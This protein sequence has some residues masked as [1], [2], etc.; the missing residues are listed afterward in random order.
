MKRGKKLCCATLILGM[1][2]PQVMGSGAVSEAASGKWRHNAKG[3]WY[4]YSDGSYAKNTWE[5][6]GG[7][8]YYFNASGYMVTGW[9]QIKGKW[10]YF[11]ASGCMVTGWKQIDGK[12]YLFSGSGVMV[13]G[14]KQT[15]NKNQSTKNWYFF[16][17]NGVMVTGWKKIS[18]KWYFFNASGVMVTGTRTIGGKEY[19]FGR[20]GALIESELA[21]AKVGDVILFGLY[22]Q[23]D[24]LS[25]GREDIEWIVLDKTADGKLLVVS[26]YGLLSTPYYNKEHMGVDWSRCTLRKWLNSTF[27]EEAFTKT[28]RAM[29]PTT[30]LKKVVNPEYGDWGGEDTED[31]VF[32]LSFEDVTKYFQD[33]DTEDGSEKGYSVA[34]ACKPTKYAKKHGAVVYEWKET[35][36]AG[37][38]KYNGNCDYWLRSAGYT[39]LHAAIV[40][41]FGEVDYYG[42]Y[43][44]YPD[45]CVRPAMYIQP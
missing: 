27:L 3:W 30:K 32:V 12:W 25:N 20:D 5:K 13:T 11:D 33:D 6:I 9:K 37:N 4:S 35:D 36:P 1:L 29:I 44:E 8:W 40:G 10:Y 17:S 22:E 38:K 15:S 21:T 23:D 28:E 16:M 18:G 31:Q 19:T 34:R 2:L 42:T 41:W 7:K 14:W 43:T 39:D 26:R 24:D 45:I